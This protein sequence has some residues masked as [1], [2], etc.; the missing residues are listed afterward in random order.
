MWNIYYQMVYS[1]QNGNWNLLI[2]IYKF[3]NF[4]FYIHDMMYTSSK[5]KLDN[6]LARTKFYWSWA[7]E[8]VLI[9]RTRLILL[10]YMCMSKNTLYTVQCTFIWKKRYMYFK[11]LNDM[12]LIY[13]FLYF[14]D[15]EEISVIQG[16]EAIPCEDILVSL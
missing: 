9:V 8:L 4:I 14:V 16:R 12:F 5:L 6:L 10:M 11:S 2:R 7:G 13:S 15:Q 3:L 1:P